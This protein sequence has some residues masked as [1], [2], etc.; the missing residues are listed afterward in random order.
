MTVVWNSRSFNAES[1]Q[2]IAKSLFTLPSIGMP[3]NIESE[4]S[5]VL[6]GTLNVLK[7]IGMARGIPIFASSQKE[8]GKNNIGDQ[9]LLRSSELG[10]SVVTDNI[11]PLPRTWEIKG[12]ITSTQ[13]MLELENPGIYEIYCSRLIVALQAIKSYFRYLRLMRA[14]FT[15]I[16]RTGDAIDVLMEDYEFVDEPE[17]EW[18]TAVTLRLREY[19]T[20]DVTK[21]GYALNMPD[22]GSIFGSGAQYVTAGTKAISNVLK[23]FM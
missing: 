18:A 21:E 11:A 15:F 16:T 6:Q 1:L 4:L 19:V 8:V 5:T 3:T 23:S 7:N 10:T 17:S 13:G 2:G 20:L 14:P 9:I 12:Y 22:T